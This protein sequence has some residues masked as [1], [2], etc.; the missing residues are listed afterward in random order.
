MLGFLL[1]LVL[2]LEVEPLYILKDVPSTVPPEPLPR[3]PDPMGIS[4]VSPEF[5]LCLLLRPYYKNLHRRLRRW[6]VFL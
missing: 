5:S 1:I 2:D 6:Q 4:G 3:L